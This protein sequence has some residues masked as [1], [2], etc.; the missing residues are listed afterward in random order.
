MSHYN[1]RTPRRYPHRRGK[2]YT[3]KGFNRVGKN[4]LK[5]GF[6]HEEI[7]LICSLYFGQWHALLTLAEM[8]GIFRCYYHDGQLIGISSPHTDAE[9]RT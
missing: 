2:C 9:R 1:I 5:D 8:S 7:G 4:L 3:R 6:T